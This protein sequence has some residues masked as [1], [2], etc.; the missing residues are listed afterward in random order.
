MIAR[1]HSL[2]RTITSLA[3]GCIDVCLRYFTS[4]AAG[5]TLHGILTGVNT[6]ACAWLADNVFRVRELFNCSLTSLL[7]SKVYISS[8]VPTLDTPTAVITLVLCEIH[9]EEL[10][11]FLFDVFELSFHGLLLFDVRKRIEAES[12]SVVLLSYV[13]LLVGTHAR[14]VVHGSL[15]L[16]AKSFVSFVDVCESLARVFGRVDIRVVFLSE[17]QEGFSDLVLSCIISHAQHL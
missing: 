2:P 9:R 14:L 5:L 6:R 4:A 10:F 13:V 15:Q 1:K 8:N 7:K 17:H 16:V 11:E 3:F 12:R